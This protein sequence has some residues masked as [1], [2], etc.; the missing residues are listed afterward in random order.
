MIGRN[1]SALVAA[2]ATTKAI[3]LLVSIALVRW[4]GVDEL[5]RYAYVLA[6]C[7]PFGA[8]ADFG[9]AT[10]AIRDASRAP[11]QARR[12]IA[13]ARRASLTL[14]TASTAAMV[15]LALLLGHEAAIVAAIGLG[16]LAS[17]VSALT[18]PSLVLLT[19]QERM[20][21]L[22]LYRIIAALL[23][24][25]ITVIVLLT[26]GGVV[27]LLGGSLL[28]GVVMWRVAQALAGAGRTTAAVPAG[29]AGAML[30]RAVPFGVL[31]A[32]F[33][34]YYR[35]D[36]V[37]LEWLAAPGE[38]GRYAAA[39]RFLDAVI[40]LAASI[41]GPLFPRLASVAVA[42]PAEARRLLE[43]GWRP[44]LVLG[45]PL[46]I[47]TLAV[48]DDLVALLFGSEFAGAARL[49][50]L[51]ILG[52]L[53]LLWVNVASHALIAVDRVWALVGVYALSVVVN[54][55]G[56][57]ILVPRWGAAGAAVATVAC[58]WLNLALVVRLLR[59][60][61]GIRLSTDGLWRYAAAMAAML[62]VVW[63][64]RPLGV[65]A[66]VALAAVAYA[67]ALWAVGYTESAE[68]R[69]ITRLLVE[70]PGSRRE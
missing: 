25:A 21:R 60:A 3:N 70:P 53:P 63:L 38:L 32:G 65:L 49:L 5:G 4:L 9:L 43:A 16:G 68:H 62:L 46:T 51:L 13:V 27:A 22:S 7:F 30:R 56:N 35:I 1:V 34:L 17:V 26:G 64:S 59:S 2:Q 57:A 40:V 52:T 33:A 12:V 15:G 54:V 14:A 18:M 39:Y 10:L 41:G 50:R 28:A 8:L 31:M 36:M 37:I 58:E 44:L 20:D 66:S 24:S 48:A 69:L 55:V 45:L 29:A 42:A 47:G 61:F 6:F 23:S 11:A 67:A 19:A